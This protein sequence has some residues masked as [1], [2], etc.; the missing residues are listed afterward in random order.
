MVGPRERTRRLKGLHLKGLRCAIDEAAEHPNNAAGKGGKVY[1]CARRVT[2]RRWRGSANTFGRRKT[3]RTAA[4]GRL[5][6]R[7]RV[8]GG[9]QT[10][11]RCVPSC[12]TRRCV[13]MRRQPGCWESVTAR[14]ECLKTSASR[15]QRGSLV[16]GTGQSLSQARFGW[17]RGCAEAVGT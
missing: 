1:G 9:T 17:I 4:T 15:T 16:G 5:K 3:R 13:A 12:R 7:R 6:R 14:V 10:S 2:N 8:D 11:C